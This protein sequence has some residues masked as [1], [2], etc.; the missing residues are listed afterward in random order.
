MK[1]ITA[2]I[3]NGRRSGHRERRC[4]EWH[5][6]C[7]EVWIDHRFFKSDVQVE[8]ATTGAELGLDTPSDLS[9]FG[10]TNGL[11]VINL[12]GAQWRNIKSVKW[13]PARLPSWSERRFLISIQK[14]QVF[15]ISGLYRLVYLKTWRFYDL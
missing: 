13:D 10:L 14:A 3:E 8:P 15:L 2:R 5:S 1:A 4:S 7:S 11:N 9:N 6:V 12:T